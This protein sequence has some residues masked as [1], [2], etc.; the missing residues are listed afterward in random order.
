MSVLEDVTTNGDKL[1]LIYPIWGLYV[2]SRQYMIPVARMN[3]KEL[4]L[5]LIFLFSATQ[6]SESA[7]SSKRKLGNQVIRK[8]WLALHNIS[9]LRGGSRDFWFVLTAENLMWFKDEEVGKHQSPLLGQQTIY[10][11]KVYYKNRNKNTYNWNIYI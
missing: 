5:I 8:G 9:M 10:L 6:K 3:R 2:F 4:F 7:G 1:F 11:Q